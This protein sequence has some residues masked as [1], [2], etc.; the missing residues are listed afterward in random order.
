MAIE[1]LRNIPV[2]FKVA[3]ISVWGLLF[4]AMLAMAV[5]A[6]WAQ[7]QNTAFRKTTALNSRTKTLR[8]KR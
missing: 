4:A 1:I 5:N 3:S 8:I 7:Y 2:A 6:L